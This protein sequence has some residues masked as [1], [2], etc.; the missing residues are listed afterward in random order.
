MDTI[1]NF[2]LL[3]NCKILSESMKIGLKA[4]FCNNKT[5]TVGNSF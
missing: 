4:F 1:Q 5:K 3:A 2:I